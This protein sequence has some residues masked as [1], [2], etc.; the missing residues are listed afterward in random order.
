M[1]RD[2]RAGGP[3]RIAYVLSRPPSFSE[4]FIESEIRAV[5]AA[6]ASVEAFVARPAGGR[7]VE[8][9]RVLRACAAHPARVAGRLTEFGASYLPR[10]LLAAACAVTLSDRMA[11]FDPDVIHAHFVNLP[12]ALAVLL[13]R[14]LGRPV[15]AMAHAADFL[16]DADPAALQRRLGRL[17]HLFVISAATARQLADKGVDMSAVPHGVVRA[18][19]DGE[20]LERPTGDAAR[21]GGPTRLVSVARLVEK[22]GIDVA[23]D[24]VARLVA[25]GHDVRYDVYGD[26]PLRHRLEHQAG[27]KGVRT[28]VTF[29]GAVP[30]TVAMAALAAADVAV[31]PCRRGAD[32]DLDGIPVFLMEAASRGVPVVT[33]AVSGIPELLGEDGGWL[34]PADDAGALAAAIG[35]AGGDPE[36]A[37]RR[38]GMMR[39]RIQD[40]FTPRLQASRLL[41]TWH[42]LARPAARLAQDP[43]GDAGAAAKASR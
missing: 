39:R 29:H 12:T 4:T 3:L 17:D 30:H 33:T 35:Q 11:R 15:T 36:L 32:G 23:V 21:P 18:A 25:S 13:G 20:Q 1:N 42:R 27:L 38:A 26:G 9:G 41:A 16:L 22:K 24:A 28:V 43:D 6:G 2:G 31:L 5:R 8:A 10:A 7:G 14:E 37:R 34:V 19:F 40:E